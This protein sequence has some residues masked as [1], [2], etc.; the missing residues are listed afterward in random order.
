MLDIIYDL[1]ST[2]KAEQVVVIV[3]CFHHGEDATKV[4]VIVGAFEHPPIRNQTFTRQWRVNVK[5][6][7]DTD[8]VENAGALVMIESR[9]QV[10]DS[11]GVHTQLLHE[12]RITQTVGSIAQGVD[13]GLGFET[14]RTSWL[15]A[16]KTVNS[17]L[18]LLVI[19]RIIRNAN[20][21]QPVSS[22]RV[23]EVGT[24]DL[25]RLHGERD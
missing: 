15:I 3:E 19:M 10:V 13:T 14:C 7:V 8:S 4:F 1:I 22:Y 9:I 12:C 24:L 16:M 6:H 17:H 23:D 20:D 21:L 11:N 25:D 5:Y 18:L 2:E